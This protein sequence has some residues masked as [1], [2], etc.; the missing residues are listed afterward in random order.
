M[1]AG[2]LVLVCD[3]SLLGHP[4][5]LAPSMH[6]RSVP[7]LSYTSHSSFSCLLFH[8]QVQPEKRF[9]KSPNITSDLSETTP[10]SM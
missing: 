6:S 1:D 3:A 9:N 10:D 8:C 4:G 5:C 2:E 7:S